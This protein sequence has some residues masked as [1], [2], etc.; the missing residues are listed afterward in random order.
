M[1]QDE[2]GEGLTYTYTYGA[3]FEPP[4][5]RIIHG[6]G[7]WEK[8]NIDYLDML[9]DASIH[10]LFQLFF[11]DIEPVRPWKMVVAKLKAYLLLETQAQRIPFISL[12]MSGTE[13]KERERQKSLKRSPYFAIDDVV[14]ES[15]K[16]DDR[17]AFIADLLKEYG[18][19]IFL[20]I[21]GEFNGP[22]K[23]YHPFLFPKAFRKIVTLFKRK[24]A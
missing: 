18:R 10:P 1:A 3:L 17:L 4:E 9:D 21:G 11:F 8:E 5:G 19:P 7:Q 14:A 2:T 13:K 15:N 23:G 24:G 12:E 22:W 20:R 6:M 16:Y